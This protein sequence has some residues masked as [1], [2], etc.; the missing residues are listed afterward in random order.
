MSSTLVAE[1]VALAE[2]AAIHALDVV[3]GVADLDPTLPTPCP[4]WELRMLLQ[5]VADASESLVCLATSGERRLPDPP[6][7]DAADPAALAESAIRELIETLLSATPGDP[8]SDDRKAAWVREAAC[9]AAIELT[10]H[11]W[12]IDVVGDPGA[13]VPQV[14]A[15]EVHNLAST[16][17]N[18]DVRRPHFRP[19]VDLAPTAT[20]SERLL[21]FLGR[22][23]AW[24]VAGRF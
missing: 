14:L 21:A 3:A 13:H 5:H 20:A 4:G 9:G 11:A 19:S 17:L 16:L 12:D 22:D 15:A 7:S 24:S 10:A 18:D 2:R 23:P 6:R 1:N 8:D